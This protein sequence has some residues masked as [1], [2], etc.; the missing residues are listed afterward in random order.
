MRSCFCRSGRKYYTSIY[1]AG[2]KYFSQTA[3][4]SRSPSKT[5]GCPGGGGG[6]WWWASYIILEYLYTWQKVFLKDSLHVEVADA[7][8]RG[9]KGP[10]PVLIAG[11]RGGSL[12]W[13]VGVGDCH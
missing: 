6:R 10:L 9:I 4:T 11:P 13:A 7:V 12:R 3:C 5:E 2:R 1:I 8:T